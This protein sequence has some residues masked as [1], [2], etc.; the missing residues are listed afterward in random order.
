MAYVIQTF[1]YQSFADLQTAVNAY[2]A[3]L[4]N[5]IIN[6]FYI[7]VQEDQRTLG[8]TYRAVLTT[9]TGGAVIATAWTLQGGEGKTLAE[10]IAVVNAY[11]AAAPAAFTCSPRINSWPYDG[12]SFSAR[13]AAWVLA[14]AT[15]GAS[16]NWT[17][18]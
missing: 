17:P 13:C 16:A 6:G 1:Q 9:K 2:L 4:T 7:S 5:P 18:V 10:A 8:R 3:G 14:N 11:I 12:G 15:I